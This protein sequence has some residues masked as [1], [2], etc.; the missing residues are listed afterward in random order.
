LTA[1]AD[2]ADVQ[3]G[4]PHPPQA[5]P[6]DVARDR[7]QTTSDILSAVGGADLDAQTEEVLSGVK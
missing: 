2:P 3:T 6:R 5:N 7:H 1:S 4:L